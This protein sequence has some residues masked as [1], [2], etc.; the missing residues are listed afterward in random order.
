M[1]HS[2][3]IIRDDIEHKIEL[4][5]HYSGGGLRG[6]RDR[7][8]APQEPDDE[9]TIEIEGATEKGEEFTLTD[10]EESKILSQLWER[11]KL[12]R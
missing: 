6:T 5:V 4:D 10:D 3:T 8:G 9:R 11:A 1:I 7:Y 12:H 2:T